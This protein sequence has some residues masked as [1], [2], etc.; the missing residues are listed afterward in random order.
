MKKILALAMAACLSAG[1]AACS[2]SPSAPS[3]PADS[4][5]DP[6]ITGMALQARPYFIN[7]FINKRM[8]TSTYVAGMLS[9]YDSTRDLQFLKTLRSYFVDVDFLPKSE[10]ELDLAEVE[11]MARETLTYRDFNNCRGFD[12][13]DG[14]AFPPAQDEAAGLLDETNSAPLG[15]DGQGAGGKPPAQ[16]QSGNWDFSPPGGG[17]TP[18]DGQTSPGSQPS[19]VILLGLSAAVL[20]IGLLIAVKYKR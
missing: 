6:D 3:A 17:F 9:A 1:L 7:S 13:M 5:S 10:A 14:Q 12:G 8:M 15:P 2:G 4:T 19:A 20:L 18:P 16:E 11:K